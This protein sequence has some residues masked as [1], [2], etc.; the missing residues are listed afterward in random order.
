MEHLFHLVHRRQ[1]LDEDHG[2][3]RGVLE[4]RQPL[5]ARGEQ[6]AVPRGLGSRL[7][8]G[9][10]EVD[11]LPAV[12]LVAAGV[13]EGQRG[14]KDRGIDGLAV[15]DDVG[16]VQMEAALPV[17]EEGQVALGDLVLLALVRVVVGQLAV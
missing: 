15:H 4:P 6:V 13:V 7:Q 14:T 3:D 2:P 10:V 5:L 17:H 1:R 8:L 16:L 12:G 9:Q 11:P